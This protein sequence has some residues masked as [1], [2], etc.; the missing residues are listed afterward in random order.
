MVIYERIK[1]F[2]LLAVASVC[3]FTA[4]AQKLGLNK[5][6]LFFYLNQDSSLYIR[7]NFVAQV[8]VRYTENN[9]GSTIQG[10][11]ANSVFD[12]GIRRTRMVMSGKFAPRTF[13]FLQFGQ[14]SLSYL[15]PRKSG[16][17]FHDI[18]IEYHIMPKAFH[19]GGGLMGWDGP[20]R[21][22]N[23]GVSSILGVDV[24]SFEEATNDINDQNVRK[25]GIF[26]KGT[27]GKIEYRFSV[28]KPFVIQTANPLPDPISKF[29]TYSTS[30]PKA[31][32]QSYVRYQF[33][34]NENMLEAGT[35][36]TYL[37]TKKVLN[38]GLGT[39]FQKDA[40][41]HTVG[42][43]T[44]H[45]NLVLL[46]ADAFADLPLN[47]AKGDAI[48]LY[49]SYCKY[50]FGDGFIKM[51]GPMNPANGVI[52]TEASLNGP[53]NAYPQLGNG[54]VVYFQGGYLL[55]KNLLGKAGTLQPYVDLTYGKFDR[56]NDPANVWDVGVNWLITG[57][58]V[59]LTFDYQNRP[60]YAL[61]PLTKSDITMRKG[62]WICQ[63]QLAL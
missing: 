46:A 26:A 28:G 17:F 14:N 40:M 24:P 44:I 15:S 48:T 57:K 20:S 41:Y 5:D 51:A 47:K 50:D 62:Q 19:L 4:H 3:F 34:E 1:A 22:S 42:T 52:L 7:L 61:D 13:F 23:S 33:F 12:I 36:G 32:L 29:S 49:L 6:G 2:L 55:R 56:L 59:K 63:F 54:S 21:Y 11:P 16:A 8:W 18:T 53:G 37:G 60:I 25:L 10:V 39:N 35:A 43:D 58:R 30:P 27:I 38:I 31:A 9:P 45:T